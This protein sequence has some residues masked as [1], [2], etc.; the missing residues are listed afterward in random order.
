MYGVKRLHKIHRQRQASAWIKSN[1]KL[2]WVQYPR[3]NFKAGRLYPTAT[4]PAQQTGKKA[5]LP[6]SAA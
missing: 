2:G 3:H 5:R 4:P 6:F 1:G